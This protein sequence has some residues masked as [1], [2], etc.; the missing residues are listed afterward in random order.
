[1]NQRPPPTVSAA[2]LLIGFTLLAGIGKWALLNDWSRFVVSLLLLILGSFAVVW[3]LNRLRNG[4]NFWRWLFVVF[5]V[6]GVV[7]ALLQPPSFQHTWEFPFFWIQALLQVLAS[8]LLFHPRS[9]PW[10]SVAKREALKA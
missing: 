3:V 2:V 4:S 5:L 7:M 6:G 10:F 1:M 8:V 9:T